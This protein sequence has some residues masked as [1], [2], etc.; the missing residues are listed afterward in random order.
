MKAAPSPTGVYGLIAEFD[1]PEDVVEATRRAYER[2]YR[3]LQALPGVT[4]E[5]AEAVP[6]APD[7]VG[8]AGAVP[9]TANAHGGHGGE[10]VARNP[11]TAAAERDVE[12]VADEIRERNVPAPPELA[13][14]G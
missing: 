5:K 8:P 10:H 6:Q 11:V 9:Q 1:R 14:I 7:H 13:Q 4:H 3:P 2:G 12:I